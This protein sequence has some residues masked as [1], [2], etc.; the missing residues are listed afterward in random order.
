MNNFRLHDQS[1]SDSLRAPRN[2][3][4]A[5][6]GLQSAVLPLGNTALVS[7]EVIF[8]LR[9][10]YDVAAT[11]RPVVFEPPLD[12]SSLIDSFGK[13]QRSFPVPQGTQIGERCCIGL[14]KYH[15]SPGIERL[16][17]ANDKS[18]IWITFKVKG[19]KGKQ[20]SARVLFQYG[21]SGLPAVKTEADIQA[22]ALKALYL[23]ARTEEV[24]VKPPLDISLLVCSRGQ[25]KKCFPF[26][27]GKNAKSKCG[28]GLPKPSRLPLVEKLSPSGEGNGI[29]VTFSA[30]DKKGVRKQ[31][32]V[33]FLCEKSGREVVKTSLDLQLEG[34]R[35]LYDALGKGKPAVRA[36]LDISR[37]I[38]GDGRLQKSFPLPGGKNVGDNIS[39]GLPKTRGSCTITS[40]LYLDKD[41]FKLT[42]NAV[43]DS[44]RH[45]RVDLIVS[46]TGIIR[47]SVVDPAIE[48][49]KGFALDRFLS[50]LF[51]VSHTQGFT[52]G[53]YSGSPLSR[54]G[55][56]PNVASGG[57]IIHA[58]WGNNPEDV[59]EYVQRYARLR[60]WNE[61]L[62]EAVHLVALPTHLNMLRAALQEF[63]RVVP[64]A[65]STDIAELEPWASTTL[66][67][68]GAIIQEELERLESMAMLGDVEGLMARRY[69]PT[70]EAGAQVIDELENRLQ[71]RVLSI[72]LSPNFIE[73]LQPS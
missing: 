54:E 2:N 1:N 3:V 24:V 21:E 31:S 72:A 59:F 17:E 41:L 68:E 6:Q 11:G 66:G 9:E 73:I 16:E 10:A 25:I 38:G 18:G 32:E 57:T 14:S 48:A 23:K 46:H 35:A 39:I 22:D 30:E 40:A 37:L 42:L 36:P 63:K 50:H 64:A 47:P 67:T 60:Q 5:D 71:A 27:D 52:G 28:I 70:L 4:F 43:T 53:R 55:F 29:W 13:T 56:E 34:V 49:C 65:A 8:R 45:A 44:G 19:P 58:K 33:L 20:E 61:K 51:A 69:T 26:P 62:V 15:S 12:A 7:S